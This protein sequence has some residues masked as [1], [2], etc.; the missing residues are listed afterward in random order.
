MHRATLKRKHSLLLCTMRKTKT[1]PRTNTARKCRNRA[2]CGVY[3]RCCLCCCAAIIIGNRTLREKLPNLF[4]H[5]ASRRCC[6]CSCKK[7]ATR[8]NTQQSVIKKQ[9][10]RKQPRKRTRAGWT[11]CTV[12]IKKKKLRSRICYSG[13]TICCLHTATYPDA[14]SPSLMT[15]PWTV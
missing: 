15:Y 11:L 1:R 9:M 4:S 12:P 3:C 8:R 10:R 2:T 5:S 14:G 6:C 7:T 13:T